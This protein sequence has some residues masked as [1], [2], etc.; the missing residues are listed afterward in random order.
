MPERQLVEL[1]QPAL[2]LVAV[3][4]PDSDSEVG[5]V[6]LGFNEARLRLKVVVEAE[7]PDFSRQEVDVYLALPLWL[8]RRK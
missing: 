3:R 6:G 8:Y 7:H 5:E 4:V 1:V 2:K